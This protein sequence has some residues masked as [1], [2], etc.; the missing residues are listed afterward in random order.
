MSFEQTA[1]VSA[2]KVAQLRLGTEVSSRAVYLAGG[3]PTARNLPLG[4]S[5][6]IYQQLIDDVKAGKAGH[7]FNARQQQAL[8]HFRQGMTEPT[9]KLRQKKGVAHSLLNKLEL[10]LSTF[11]ISDFDVFLNG[12]EGQTES[13]LAPY[14]TEHVGGFV[15]DQIKQNYFTLGMTTSSGRWPG[16]S[17]KTL[18]DKAKDLK[19]RKLGFN[20]QIARPLHRRTAIP[21][22]PNGWEAFTYAN[23]WGRFGKRRGYA[24]EGLSPDAMRGKV[25]VAQYTRNCCYG[26]NA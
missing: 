11:R 2:Q 7:L 9:M 19:D 5:H 20:T 14:I 4:M 18:D 10:I 8:R 16:L 26:S 13:L 24:A 12:V 3:L 23:G 6:L 17:Q 25:Q 21:T 22:L 15:G 1:A